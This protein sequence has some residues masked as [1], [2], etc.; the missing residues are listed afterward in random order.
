M[1]TTTFHQLYEAHARDV[2]RFARFLS[3]SE[4][5]AED[6]TAETFLR[7]WAG[8]GSVRVSTARAYLLAI[9]RNLVRDRRRHARR[10]VEAPVPDRAVQGNAEPALELA[11]VTEAL[12]QL[13]AEYREPLALVASGLS[14]EEA[15]GVLG[16]PLSTVKIRVFRARVMLATVLDR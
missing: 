15:G 1:D 14:Y 7:A 9:A 4:D 8:R 10:W 13:P 3:G 11:R 5:T 12:A 6:V 2:Y 16:L